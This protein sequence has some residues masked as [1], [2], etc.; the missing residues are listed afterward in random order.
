MN[1]FCLLIEAAF[2]C[3]GCAVSSRFSVAE[4]SKE[5]NVPKFK[6]SWYFCIFSVFNV[7]LDSLL[8]SVVAF[9]NK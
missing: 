2:S 4:S 1:K 9:F 3:S 6:N 5:E 7:R 8:F